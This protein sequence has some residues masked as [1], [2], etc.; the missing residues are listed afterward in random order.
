MNTLTGY[1]YV[2]DGHHYL[3]KNITLTSKFLNVIP[4]LLSAIFLVDA[5]RRLKIVA[6]GLFEIEI[7]Q[8]IWHLWTFLFLI[9]GGV[10]LN[11]STYHAW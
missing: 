10:L 8:M 9:A 5:L 6:A 1:F 7:W 11:I 4:D 2:L 3:N